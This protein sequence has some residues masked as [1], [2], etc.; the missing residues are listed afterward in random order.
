MQIPAWRADRHWV[1]LKRTDVRAAHQPCR[2][3]AP[4]TVPQPSIR[5]KAPDCKPDTADVGHIRQQPGASTSGREPDVKL[6]SS[7]FGLERKDFSKFVH[8]FRQA[9]PYIKGHRGKTFIIVVPGEVQASPLMAYSRGWTVVHPPKQ[10]LTQVVQQKDLLH[11]LLE[12]VT[13]LHGRTAAPL[14]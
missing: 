13:L 11:S 1:P 4:V 3:A 9:S 14:L 10:V 6:S 7:E 12:D 5:L 2:C 8:F